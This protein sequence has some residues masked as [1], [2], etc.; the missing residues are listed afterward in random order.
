MAAPSCFLTRRFLGFA[1]EFFVHLALSFP[2]PGLARRTYSEQRLMH[3]FP[4][5]PSQIFESDSRTS[6]HVPLPP[7]YESPPRDIQPPQ[8][9]HPPFPA[10]H[11][12]GLTVDSFVL[13]DLLVDRSAKCRPSFIPFP[14][15][16]T[17]FMQ[18]LDVFKSHYPPSFGHCCRQP[19]LF[20]FPIQ[21]LF[22]RPLVDE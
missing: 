2:P 22:F 4:A 21:I 6:L 13:F 15:C 19:P 11:P 16:L 20:A 5:V 14:G 10:Y 8:G 17:P 1:F 9:G 7:P 18:S 3:R 12:I